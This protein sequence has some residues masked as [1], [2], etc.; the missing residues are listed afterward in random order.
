MTFVF[1]YG[2]NWQ[3]DVELESVDARKSRLKHPKII[4]KGGKAPKQYDYDG[5]DD[6]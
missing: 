3:F 2:D 5:D 4:A 6:W 1:D